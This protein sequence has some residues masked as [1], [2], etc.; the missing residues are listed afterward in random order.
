M[1]RAWLESQGRSRE[2]KGPRGRREVR[3][4]EGQVFSKRFG[5]GSF[6]YQYAMAVEQSSSPEVLEG[7]PSGRAPEMTATLAARCCMR[8][9]DMSFEGASSTGKAEKAQMSRVAWAN[10][11]HGCTS[12]TK[13]FK[14]SSLNVHCIVIV[15]LHGGGRVGPGLPLATAESG[16]ARAP[17]RDRHSHTCGKTSTSLIAPPADSPIPICAARAH[18]PSIPFLSEVTSSN[19]TVLE[20][21][22]SFSA[23]NYM[24]PSRPTPHALAGSSIASSILDPC[25]SSWRL[26]ASFPRCNPA[27]GLFANNCRWEGM[28]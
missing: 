7:P 10:G 23:V 19:H 1:W 21:I 20:M 24:W 4:Q 11:K 3:T 13:T 6:I 8:S 14:F 17:I 9:A 12:V 26:L 27:R 16:R 28:R 25:I 22:A 5:L 15:V 2:V 18:F